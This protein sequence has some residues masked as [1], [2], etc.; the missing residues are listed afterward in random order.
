M[1]SAAEMPAPAAPVVALEGTWVHLGGRAVVRDVDL[2]ADPGGWTT[3]IGPNGAG[4]TTVLRAAAG[5]VPVSAGSVTVAGRPVESY[6]VRERARLLA[7]MPQHPTIPPRMRVVDYVLLGRT[8]HLGHGL[9]PTGEDVA[10]V[11]RIMAAVGL[12]G[13]GSRRVDQ[14]SGGER[15]RA[16]VAR[17]MAQE[18]GILLLDE[19][20]T[21]LDIGHQ[22]EVLE[23]V[24]ELRRAHGLTVV[25]TMH[26]L[27]LAAQYSERLTLLV[28]GEVR[29]A[30]TP[31]EVLT[32]A[33]LSEA[34]S[35]ELDVVQDAGEII[36]IPRRRR[37]HG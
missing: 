30:G 1:T 31:G 15:Q 8:A 20:T 21:S 37:R 36:V 28:G 12:D 27:G 26:D 5:L 29:C 33:R 11:A 2:R 22:Q 16:V 14:L 32:E 23:T 13:F 6:G 34:Y 25:A 4:K 7:V 24:D 19:P 35:A 17:A 10:A 3:V 18:A 9:R